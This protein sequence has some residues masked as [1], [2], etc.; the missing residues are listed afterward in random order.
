MSIEVTAIYENG[1]FK[2][3]RKLDLEERT[4]VQLVI[5]SSPLDAAQDDTTGWRAIDEL[6]G[7]IEDGPAETAGRDHD[8]YLNQ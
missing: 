5:E 2:P 3:E 7:F 8:K 4:R 1:A 6:I